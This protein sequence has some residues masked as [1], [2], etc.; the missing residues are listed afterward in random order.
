MKVK[1][2]LMVQWT[3]QECGHQHKQIVTVT[4]PKDPASEMDRHNA[5]S[6]EC[7]Q[8]G[9]ESPLELSFDGLTDIA[10]RNPG[11]IKVRLREDIESKRLLSNIVRSAKR[12]SF[13]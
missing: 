7:V 3:C 8:C 10:I 11:S 13:N 1:I 2:S 6:L 4:I 12:P 9:W 5:Y